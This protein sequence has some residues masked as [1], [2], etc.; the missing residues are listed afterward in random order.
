M[1]CEL[2]RLRYLRLL[3][4]EKKSGIRAK[5]KSLPLRSR[6]CRRVK[7]IREWL[8]SPRRDH[9]WPLGFWRL[10]SRTWPVA[11]LQITPNQRQ[12]SSPSQEES[13]LFGSLM[14]D[15]KAR[16]A[17]LSLSIQAEELPAVITVNQ[18]TSVEAGKLF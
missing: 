15:L 7:A 4:E 6:R 18:S 1:N 2:W 17:A 8:I 13:W 11:L 16:R 9:E 10:S 12:Q 5:L 14:V 3:K